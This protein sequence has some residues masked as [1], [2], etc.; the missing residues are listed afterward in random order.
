MPPRV[1]SNRGGPRRGRNTS[2]GGHPG[3]GSRGSQLGGP[4]S[5]DTTSAAATPLEI[6]DTPHINIP[7]AIGG[8]PSGNRGRG[9]GRGRGSSHADAPRSPPL[10][11]ATTTSIQVIDAETATTTIPSIS[12]SI[13]SQIPFQISAA[14]ANDPTV[15]RGQPGNRGRGAGRRGV[16]DRH[17]ITAISPVV[18]AS[19]GETTSIASVS[20]SRAALIP[21]ST[22]VNP[23]ITPPSFFSGQVGNRGRGRGASRG[24]GP[25]APSIPATAITGETAPHSV[26]RGQFSS[27]RGGYRGS[28]RPSSFGSPSPFSGYS[29]PGGGGPSG[30]FVAGIP[31]KLY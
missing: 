24:G 27:G 23:P 12:Q 20:Q 9:R 17:T 13:P 5:I 22:Q 19:I 28:A 15:F 25:G 31:G 18:T 6:P 16:P 1:S 26:I 30:G 11:S 29:S 2:H 21:I 10:A 8:R 3:D 7:S 4:S 14:I